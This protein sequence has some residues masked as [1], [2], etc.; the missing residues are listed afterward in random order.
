MKPESLVPEPPLESSYSKRDRR[1]PLEDGFRTISELI[2]S[3]ET[4]FVALCVSGRGSA[5]SFLF[6]VPLSRISLL[7]QQ[8]GSS[9]HQIIIH[10]PPIKKTKQCLLRAKTLLERLFFPLGC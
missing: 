2:S 1:L 7:I 3:G 9:Y 6:Q 4:P 10:T 8:N 5:D